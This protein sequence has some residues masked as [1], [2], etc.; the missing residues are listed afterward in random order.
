MILAKK[1]QLRFLSDPGLSLSVSVSAPLSL[2]QEAAAS[3]DAK[4]R[5]SLVTCVP[6]AQEE[7]P[8]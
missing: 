6:A 4:V 2:L 1:L 3:G 8:C 5:N 7:H